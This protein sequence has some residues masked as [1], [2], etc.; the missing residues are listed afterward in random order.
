MLLTSKHREHSLDY[1]LPLP[2]LL[3]RSHFPGAD[4]CTP[5]D[6]ANSQ[7]PKFHILR[8][9]RPSSGLYPSFSTLNPNP[10]TGHLSVPLPTRVQLGTETKH[11]SFSPSQTPKAPFPSDRRPPGVRQWW[12]RGLWPKNP[13][14]GVASGGMRE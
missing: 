14:G 11:K 10:F 9:T 5:H 3:T 4:D 1:P 13:P 7:I 6:D 2:T 12:Y 8:H